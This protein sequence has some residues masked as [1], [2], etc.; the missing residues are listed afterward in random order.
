[1]SSFLFDDEVEEGHSPR[2]GPK[3]SSWVLGFRVS[4]KGEPDLRRTGEMAW[5]GD[6]RLVVVSSEV[7][8]VGDD[9]NRELTSRDL[10][11]LSL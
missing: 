3:S 1:M 11:L 10:G 5:F 8:E 9:I 6:G 4:L 2:M 7:A